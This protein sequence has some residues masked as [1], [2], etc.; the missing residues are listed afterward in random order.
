MVSFRL[1]QKRGILP[2][3]KGK[4]SGH[5]SLFL[6]FFAKLSFVY[7]APKIGHVLKWK[8]GEGAAMGSFPWGSAHP[9]KIWLIRSFFYEPPSEPP[10]SHSVTS[11]CSRCFY[12]WC[13]LCITDLP[14]TDGLVGNL[15][16]CSLVHGWGVLAGLTS[17]LCCPSWGRSTGAGGSQKASSHVWRLSWSICDR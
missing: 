1:Q 6:M 7:F 5:L 9:C 14:N 15:L 12:L 17:A 13:L 8:W 3:L 11:R 2:H 16:C 4:N 10:S